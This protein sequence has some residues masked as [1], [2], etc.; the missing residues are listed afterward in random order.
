MIVRC[1]EC[2]SYF[3]DVYRT[4]LCPHETFAA[5]DGQNRFQHH[6]E[7]YLS[8]W[9]PGGIIRPISPGEAVPVPLMIHV[10]FWRGCA[11]H[12]LMALFRFLQ[13]EYGVLQP[14]HFQGINQKDTFIGRLSPS[15]N[16]P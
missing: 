8:P 4:K 12:V 14:R 10:G 3:E 5:N 9:A 15:T 13:C 2:R 6:P 1:A 7:A 11:A 16:F